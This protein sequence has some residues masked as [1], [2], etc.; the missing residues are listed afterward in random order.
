MVSALVMQL[1][2]SVVRIPSGGSKS[3]GGDYDDNG[4]D[5]TNV[6]DA[7]VTINTSYDNAMRTAHTFMS[8]YLKK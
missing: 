7:D 8:A 4:G 3:S 1:V 5:R 2:Q 6:E